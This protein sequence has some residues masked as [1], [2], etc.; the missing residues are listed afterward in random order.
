LA[1][2]PTSPFCVDAPGTPLV[3]PANTGCDPT[4]LKRR[5]FTHTQ[6]YNKPFDVAYEDLAKARNLRKLEI[7]FFQ[8]DTDGSGEMSLDEFR[9]AM[10]QP[11]IQKAFAAL[12]VQPHQ[13]EMVFKTL[14]KRKTGEL[15][16]NEFMTGLTDLVGTDI[17]GTGKELDIETLR[18]A[19]KA[20][21]KHH[22]H[23]QQMFSTADTPKRSNSAPQLLEKSRTPGLDLGPVHLLPKVKVQRAFVHSAS[24]L[25]LHSAMAKTSHS[26]K[27]Y[28]F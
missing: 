24:A 3:N 18:P 13:S 1:H 9:E 2:A 23:V 19:F 17:D 25:A 16:I 14:D 5:Q 28:T 10:R 4:I 6:F 7:L 15:S 11:T 27:K 12:G 26:K 22:V 20:K 21:Q 8:A